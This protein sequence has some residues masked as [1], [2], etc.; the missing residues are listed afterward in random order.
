MQRSPRVWSGVS[1]H[2]AVPDAA[3]L[4]SRLVRTSIGLSLKR[5][6]AAGTE[7]VPGELEMS[8]MD[9]DKTFVAEFVHDGERIKDNDRAYF[10]LAL[11]YST[12]DGT[13]VVR[14]HNLSLPVTSQVRCWPRPPP[15][16]YHPQMLPGGHLASP[17]S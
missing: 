7:R 15:A 13:R 8:V 9:A 14:V 6:L 16:M 17:L 4:V 10:Q 2:H 1:W 11:L 12:P 3:C 5:Y